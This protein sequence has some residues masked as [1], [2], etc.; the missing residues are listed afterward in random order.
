MATKNPILAPRIGSIVEILNDSNS[1]LF[2]INNDED[3]IKK[4]KKIMNNENDA[5]V[6]NAYGQVK[7]IYSMEKR[8]KKFLRLLKNEK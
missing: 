7:N 1:Y 2:D 3:L 4:I 8:V 5:I 6:N